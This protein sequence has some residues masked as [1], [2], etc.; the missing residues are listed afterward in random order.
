M[1]T[2]EDK[3]L[4]LKALC[5]L[6]PYNTIVSVPE[7]E[8]DFTG[9]KIKWYKENLTSYLLHQI[10]EEG[11]LE[12]I[13]PYL[14]PMSSMTEEERAEVEQLIKDNRPSPYGEINNSGMDN[15]LASVSVTSSCLIDWLNEHHF[16]FRNLIGK[17]LAL[18]APK[19]MYY[20]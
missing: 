13:K 6:L 16:D 19:D 9:Y 15:L 17:K 1:Y 3:E 7:G 4:L 20:E 2:Q 12:F 8:D 11:A 14:R 10:V 18:E 5:A